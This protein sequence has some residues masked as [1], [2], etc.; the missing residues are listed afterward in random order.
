VTPAAP[1]AGAAG[2]AGGSG[3][4]AAGSGG[5]GAGTAGAPADAGP[6]VPDAAPLP[7][8]GSSAPSAGSAA[9][10]AGPTGAPVLPPITDPGA[11]GPFEIQVIETVEGLPMHGIIAPKDLGRGGIKHPVLIWINGAS[12]GFSSYRAMLDNVAAHGFFL[13]DDKQSSFDADPEVEGQRAAIDW[14]VAQ[15]STQGSKYFGLIDP[16][17]IAIGGHSM[18]SVASFG[19]VADPR[20]KTSI[21]MAGG[22]TGNPEGSDASTLQKLHAPAAFL[23]GAR[24]TNGLPRCEADFEAVPKSAPVFFGVL[25]GVGHTDEFSQPN[26]G[27]WGRVVIA[28]LRWQLAGD[29]SFERS[30]VGPDCEFCKGDW[31]TKKNAID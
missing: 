12:A 31:T 1:I 17:R 29:A 25:A 21:H 7:T 19:N 13:I 6:P 4:L 9:P 5:A 3:N 11:K 8:A 27:R 14:V 16:E 23:C 24:D 22:I 15:A 30:F 2:L 10:D 20:V 18:G 28:W 26:G